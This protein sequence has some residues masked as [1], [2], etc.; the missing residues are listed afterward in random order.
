[1]HVVTYPSKPICSFMLSID[2][3]LDHTV[4]R[5]QVWCAA[6]V[7]Q[8]MATHGGQPMAIVCTHPHEKSSL[9][10]RL[11]SYVL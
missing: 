5:H 1:M 6:G 10:I 2:G 11:D 8:W 7:V 4:D 3:D 9:R